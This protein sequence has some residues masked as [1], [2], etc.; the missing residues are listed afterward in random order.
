MV[1]G[2]KGSDRTGMGKHVVLPNPKGGFR[3]GGTT[4]GPGKGNPFKIVKE[5]MERRK[6]EEE[7]ER[8]WLKLGG[9]T[10][11]GLLGNPVGEVRDLGNG[12]YTRDFE[13]GAL[14]IRSDVPRRLPIEYYKADID[15]AGIRC[16]GTD[17][18]S[19]EDEPYLII[20]AV[21]PAGAFLGGNVVRTWRSQRFEDVT[22]GMVFG[23]DL[24]AFNDLPIGPKGLYLKLALMD[25]EHGD[26]EELR[27]QIEEKGSKLAREIM[28]AAALVAGLDI[29][30][31]VSDQALD[32]EIL[33]TLGDISV[34]LLTGILKDDKIDEKT[35]WIPGD[36][37]KT[38]ADDVNAYNDS[39]VDHNDPAMAVV[40]TNFPR[41]ALHDM[42]WLFSG[43][44]GS[45]KVFLR[46]T[47]RHVRET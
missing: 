37:L 1:G 31:A 32:S 11:I 23:T 2:I 25:H 20:T 36:L 15:V 4:Q 39:G 41:D 35:W 10:D 12:H 17:D 19:G 34:G 3:P 16:F 33:S 8:K 27:K 30:D 28:D 42:S 47:P 14:H 26:E 9:P 13:M 18:P 46:V 22:Q 40:K 6:A 29:D 43:G 44:G 45:Y 5:A 38:W 7:I 21:S 24:A